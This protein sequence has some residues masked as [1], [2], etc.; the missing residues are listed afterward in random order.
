MTKT[1]FISDMTCSKCVA[2]VTRAL[3][4]L[5]GVS[6]KVDL[7]AGTAVVT[8]SQDVPDQTLRDAVTDAGYQVTGIE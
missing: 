1:I 5:P 7:D 6:A 4:T 8:L 2:H 3:E